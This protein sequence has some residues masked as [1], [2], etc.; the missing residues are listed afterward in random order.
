ML[1]SV[2]SDSFGKA[3]SAILKYVLD[4]PDEKDIDFSPFMH[5]RMLAKPEDI[6]KAM[7]GSF[8]PEQAN[9][10]KITFSHLDSVNL[11][12][13]NLQTAIDLLAKPFL[14]QIDLLVTIPA[15]THHSATRIIA[16]IG[17]DMSVFLDAKHFVLGRA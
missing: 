11:C 4:N 16:E 14:P 15:V 5:H 6:S 12:R 13:E 8:S 7:N 2:V 1:S 10:V 9:K 3:A 17:A